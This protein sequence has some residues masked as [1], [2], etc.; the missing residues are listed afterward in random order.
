MN[1][2][3]KRL[4]V[5]L[6]GLVVVVIGCGMIAYGYWPQINI[7]TS[8]IGNQ[9]IPTTNL[10]P[11]AKLDSRLPTS[12]SADIIIQFTGAVGPQAIEQQGIIKPQITAMGGNILKSYIFAINGMH[13]T[14]P[15]S[16]LA[17]IARMNSVKAVYQNRK[18]ASIIGSDTDPYEQPIEFLSNT[19]NIVQS[20]IL[21]S[22][23]M[24]GSG[25]VVAIMDTGVDSDH[26][27]LQRNGESMIIESFHPYGPEYSHWH[28]T[29]VAGC[30]ASQNP[31]ALGMAPDCRL[32]SVNVF[33]SDGNGWLDWIIEGAD[34]II[35]WA[36]NHPSTFVISTNSW[37]I[38]HTSWSQWPCFTYS[39]PSIMHYVMHNMWRNGIPAV[40]SVGNEGSTS[41]AHMT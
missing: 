21:H 38:N 39:N 33:D 4:N 11:A 32:L 36:R 8:Q 29:A 30:I 9:S 31:N 19:D 18:V 40:V 34:F 25:V 15:A 5:M 37:G 22:N 28:G 14:I 7:Y 6:V 27:Y 20:N 13:V 35:S 24:L 41:E 2:K 12:G 17:D 1:I 10:D 26:V 16:K 23:G 3:Q